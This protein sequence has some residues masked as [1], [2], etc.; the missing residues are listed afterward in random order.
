MD[1]QAIITNDNQGKHFYN[2]V[3]CENFM[4]TETFT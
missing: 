1:T 4:S 2:L 3:F